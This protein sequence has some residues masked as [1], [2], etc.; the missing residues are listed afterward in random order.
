MKKRI[1]YYTIEKNDKPLIL[2][3]SGF[4]G[5]L[6][7]IKEDEEA[8]VWNVRETA[9][10]SRRAVMSSQ[11]RL[12][13]KLIKHTRKAISDM[14]KSWFADQPIASHLGKDG[15]FKII[16]HYEES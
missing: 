10:R 2:C 16:G 13:N 15:V 6:R 4:K 9:D 11:R 1:I 8:T 12:M 5:L 7:P 3:Q 14:S